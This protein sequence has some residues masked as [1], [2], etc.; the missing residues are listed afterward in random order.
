MG[1]N[2]NDFFVTVDGKAIGLIQKI[3]VEASAE[4]VMPK[5]EITFPD[6]R[7]HEIDLKDNLINSIQSLR[8]FPYVTLKFE[9]LNF[10]TEKN[11]S[12]NAEPIAQWETSELPEDPKDLI[13]PRD[14]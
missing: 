14:L 5:V 7:G 9:S 13:D 6:L 12:A 4:E 2:V 10:K 8:G 11:S 3:T 1:E